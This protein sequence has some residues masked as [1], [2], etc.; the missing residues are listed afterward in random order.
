MSIRERDAEWMDYRQ[1]PDSVSP[2]ADRRALRVAGDALATHLKLW[3]AAPSGC[4]ICTCRGTGLPR[5][6]YCVAADL[7]AAWKEATDG[8]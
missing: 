6:W 2:S 3:T 7:L 4:H 5:C 1:S 8:R